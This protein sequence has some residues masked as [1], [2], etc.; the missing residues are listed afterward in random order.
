MRVA[1]KSYDP[2]LTQL[3]ALEM[4]M[5]LLSNSQTSISVVWENP[6]LGKKRSS[7]IQNRTQ[8][9]GLKSGL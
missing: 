2:F 1:G 3:G 4:S 5:I 8:L 7:N 9:S 6:H